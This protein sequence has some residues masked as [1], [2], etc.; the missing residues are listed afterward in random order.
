MEAANENY[1]LSGETWRAIRLGISGEYR[2]RDADNRSIGIAGSLGFLNHENE[3]IANMI[4]AA[5]KLHAAALRALDW[6]QM[7][8]DEYWAKYGQPDPGGD[9]LARQLIAALALAE[10]FAA[11]RTADVPPSDDTQGKLF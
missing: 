5:P 7:P 11:D 8:N 6:F 3:K 10:G 1:S 2:I 9:T 4:V